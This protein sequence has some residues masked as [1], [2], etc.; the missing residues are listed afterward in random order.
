LDRL[1]RIG[2]PLSPLISSF[3]SRLQKSAVP[4]QSEQ[5][6]GR[7]QNPQTLDFGMYFQRNARAGNPLAIYLSI[8]TLEGVIRELVP[9]YG[10]NC[11]I[12]VIYST[13]RAWEVHPGEVVQATL[14]TIQDGPDYTPD[15]RSAFVRVG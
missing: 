12:T 1:K 4:V 9:F 6:S 10:E 15:T 3:G 5:N 7:D 14:A 11:P 13:G 2:L 8:H